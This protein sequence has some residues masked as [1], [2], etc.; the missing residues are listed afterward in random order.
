MNLLSIIGLPRSGTTM[1]GRM[2]SAGSETQYREE[3]NPAWR[4]RNWLRLGHEQFDASHATP[5]VKDFIRG[6][7]AGQGDGPIVE[8]TPANCLRVNFVETV[9]PEAKIIFLKR[10]REAI[11]RSILRKWLEWD[12]TNSA[13]LGSNE[14]FHDMRGQVGKLAF[15]HGSELPRYVIAGIRSRIARIARRPPSFWGPEFAGWQAIDGMPYQEV[16][17][18]SVAAMETALE[19]GIEQC[20]LPHV[21]LQYEDILRDPESV[22]SKALTELDFSELRPS[23]SV[24]SATKSNPRE[25]SA[26]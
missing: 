11:K 17:E 9:V 26:P 8:K 19:N 6:K 22:V 14:A 16:V 4:F 24:V 3:P 7:L 1:L 2:L 10:D 25:H 15:V 23:Y 5:E 21:T 20:R 12:D 13:Q 18:A